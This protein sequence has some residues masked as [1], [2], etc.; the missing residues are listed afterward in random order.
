MKTLK[1]TI[2][3]LIFLSTGFLSACMKD[4]DEDFYFRDA[5][6]EFDIATTTSNAPGRSYPMLAALAPN[7]GLQTY[8][9]N[10]LGEHLPSDQSLTIRVL[11]DVSTAVEGEHY[12][13]P[14]GN[15][16]VLS[17]GSSFAELQVEILDFPTEDDGENVA[18]VFE[19][20]GND[21]VKPSENHKAIGVQIRTN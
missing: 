18:V 20:V 17:A 1:Y 14:N 2:I 8:R 7:A 12:N 5:L 21:V 16:T 9:I 11:S 13:L 3:V 6:V 15:T 4:V 19:I 10:L